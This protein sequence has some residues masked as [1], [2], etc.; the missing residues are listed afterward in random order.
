MAQL[1]RSVVDQLMQMNYVEHE[2]AKERISAA[3][4]TDCELRD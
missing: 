2:P 1:Q 4:A 3:L